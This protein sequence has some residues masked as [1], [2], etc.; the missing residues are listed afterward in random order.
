MVEVNR[1]IVNGD[2]VSNGRCV[3]ETGIVNHDDGEIDIHYLHPLPTNV[4]HTYH[5]SITLRYTHTFLF[6]ISSFYTIHTHGGS[7]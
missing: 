2:D 4:G 1:V 6:S 3:F 7:V 5:H